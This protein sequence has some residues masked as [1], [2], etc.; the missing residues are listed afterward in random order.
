LLF[1][2]KISKPFRF[3]CPA[4]CPCFQKDITV[5]RLPEKKVIGYVQQPL[6]GGFW[7]P[8]LNV[9]DQPGGQ[10]LGYVQGPCCCIGG[11]CSSDW[12]LYDANGREHVKVKRDGF[13]ELGLARSNFTTSDKYEV[14]FEDKSLSVDD[15]VR[16]MSTVIFIDYLF[17]EG[18]TN[19]ICICCTCP[20]QVI[21]CSIFDCSRVF[22]F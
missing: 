16:L 15:K 14:T 13:A 10:Y 12:K 3:C 4:I 22:F 19:T 5:T 21:Q 18:E 9:Y 8:T 7:T 20:P 17:F 6:C 11:C 2:T 1:Q